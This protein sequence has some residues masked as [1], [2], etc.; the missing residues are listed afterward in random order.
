[1]ATELEPVKTAVVGIL[2][3]QVVLAKQESHWVAQGLEIDYAAAGDSIEDVKRRFHEGLVATIQVHF[4]RF[5]S[6]DKLIIPAETT[7]WLELILSQSQ[8]VLL[9]SSISKH[10]FE[11]PIADFPFGSIRYL[12]PSLED[13]PMPETG[14]H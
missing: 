4:D 2:D 7:D 14:V 6:L 9:H 12:V 5:G 11:S 8:R 3:L 10:K 13:E 1:M